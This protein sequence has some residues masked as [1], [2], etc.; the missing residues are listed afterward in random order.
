MSGGVW[1]LSFSRK[2]I[3][4]KR[5]PKK[6]KKKNNK[7]KISALS[8]FFL[9]VFILSLNFIAAT[10][11]GEDLHLNIQTLY[12]N[13]SV[14]TGTFAFAFNISLADT[15]DAIVYSNLTTLT[16]D[17]RGIVSYYL[18]NVSL[19]YTDQYWLCYYRDGTL[20]NASKIA[21]TPYTFSARNVTLSGVS[22]DTNFNAT[23]YNVTANY[24]FF[25]FLGSLLNRITTLFIQNIQF[26]GTINGSG[27]ITTT[28]RIGIGTESPQNLLN[29][30]GDINAT[31]SIFSQGNNLSSAFYYST[32]GSGEP[33][34]NANY[35][36]FTVVYGYALNDSLW[37]LNYSDYLTTKN[38]A[39]NDSLWTLN[40]STYLLKPTWAQVT[41]GTM[42]SWANVVNG[43][44]LSYAQALNNTLMQQANWNATN[45][46]YFDL[47]KANTVGAFNQTFDTSTLFIDSVSD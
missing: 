22:V 11:I 40:Y 32:N 18:N 37:T 31:T 9:A 30:I 25:S 1:Y 23:G 28:G 6:K 24:G 46:S 14:R 21:R 16:T 15:C 4:F 35:S 38:Y 47:N 27:N 8:L 13:G 20:I 3:E 43:T 33:K 45:T 10:A 41:N 7:S 39:L 29:V 17:A 36:N 26:N 44:M 5:Y 2:K 12:D 42:A 34:W 19:N